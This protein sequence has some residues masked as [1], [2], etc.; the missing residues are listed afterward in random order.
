MGLILQWRDDV[1]TVVP[2]EVIKHFI[3]DYDENG[4]HTGMLGFFSLSIFY[5]VFGSCNHC[6]YLC[7]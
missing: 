6:F 3:Q 7:F 2:T 5:I 1:T 4:A